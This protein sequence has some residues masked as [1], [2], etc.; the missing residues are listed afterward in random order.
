MDTGSSNVDAARARPVAE[1]AAQR[2]SPPLVP[3][4]DHDPAFE[5]RREQ[6]GDAPTDHAVATHDEDVASLRHGRSAH[7][8]CVVGDLAA[9]G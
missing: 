9:R 4:R 8:R 5:A 6:R 1:L 2:F 7:R 3:A